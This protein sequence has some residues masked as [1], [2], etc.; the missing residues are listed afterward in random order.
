MELLGLHHVSILTGKAEKN[1]QFFTKVLGMRLVKKTVNQDNTQSYHLFY[2][3][4]EGTPGTE[5]TF[6]DIPGLARTH[7]G[8]SDISTVSLRVKS[9][10]S[11]YFWKERFEQ[12]G[13]EY[14]EIAKRANRDTLAFKDYEGTR[15]LLVADNGEKGVRA[16]V[17][18]K[19]EDIPLEHAIIGLGPV[20]LTVGTAEPT[21]DV[22]TNIMGFRYVGSYPSLAGDHR[23]ILVY[24]TG[25]GGSGAEVHIETRPDLPKVRLGR[26]GVH[27]VAFRVPNEE[28]YNKWASRLDENS[29]P[30]SCKVERYY[31]KALYF[32]E[33]NGI[34]FELSTDTPGF[35]TDEPLETMGQTLALPP[36]LEPKRKEI[37]E[38]LRSL[39][40]DETL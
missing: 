40:L 8:A 7:E 36:F 3:D 23:D 19:R 35:A 25:E 6:F 17:P 4:G 13:V 37:E 18:W 33:P 20:T 28:E 30:N 15:L 34:L 29:L 10:D 2:A 11:L 26:G 38:K 1:Y 24:A 9:T 21:V 32:R 22:L 12:Y 39:D 14:E 5:V 31:F 16:G 27:H